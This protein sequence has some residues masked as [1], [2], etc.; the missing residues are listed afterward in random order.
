MFFSFKATFNK[1]IRFILKNT[2]ETC[3]NLF[4]TYKPYPSEK[5]D[6]FVNKRAV[7]CT[8]RLWRMEIET[9]F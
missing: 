2:Q 7:N 6:N 1:I 9:F 4:G 5:F 8:T 3:L